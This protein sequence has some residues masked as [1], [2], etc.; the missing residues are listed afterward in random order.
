MRGRKGR[1]WGKKVSPVIRVGAGM[2][3]DKT[4]RD[5]NVDPIL[6]PRPIAIPMQYVHLPSFSLMEDRVL[7]CG[8]YTLPSKPYPNESKFY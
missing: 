4:I 1:G 6:R 2:G 5:R 8:L 7:V 3:Q